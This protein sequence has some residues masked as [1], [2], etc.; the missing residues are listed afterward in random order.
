MQ[1][2]LKN[3][4]ERN[5]RELARVL[6]DGEKRPLNQLITVAGLSGQELCFAL[7]WLARENGVDFRYDG[8][9]LCIQAKHAAF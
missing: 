3:E 4:I 7:G 6:A 8:G 2:E 1:T 5:A 9:A